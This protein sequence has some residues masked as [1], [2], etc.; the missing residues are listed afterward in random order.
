[1][2]CINFPVLGKNWRAK[3]LSKKA[4]RRKFKADCVAIQDMDKRK[5][6]FFHTDL[7]TVVHELVHSYLHELCVGRAG[8]TDT[9]ALEEVFCEMVAKYGREILDLAD[10]LHKAMEVRDEQRNFDQQGS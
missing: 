4:F 6:W 10:Q 2:K 1:M 3:V 7:E 5:M 9:D 8:I